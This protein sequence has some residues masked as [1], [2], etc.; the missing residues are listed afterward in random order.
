MN[1]YTFKQFHYTE[2]QP[3]Q[4]PYTKDNNLPIDLGKL[5]PERHLCI[6]RFDAFID[7]NSA[8]LKQRTLDVFQSLS[9][10]TQELVK[11]QVWKNAGSPLD[12]GVDFGGEF[13]RAN[14]L[15]E[16]VLSA[17]RSVVEDMKNDGVDCPDT[18]LAVMDAISLIVLQIK[19][20]IMKLISWGQ[21]SS[22]E[23][24]LPTQRVQ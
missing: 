5:L 12:R 7:R 15:H 23:H 21:N 20:W 9:N 3:A 4:I 18:S 17:F 24:P 2:A 14:P 1:A 16:S 13:I 11:Q 8:A 10:E 22:D 19:S 6:S